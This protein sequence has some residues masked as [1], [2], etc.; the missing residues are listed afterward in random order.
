MIDNLYQEIVA[1]LK[2]G[3]RFAL[4]TI[5]RTR[6]SSP[7]QVGAKMIVYPDGTTW[8]TIG[9]GKFEKLAIE[10]SLVLLNGNSRNCIKKYRF[11]KFGDDAT[12][13]CCGGEAELYM[14]VYT[15][16]D[17]IIIFGGGHIGGE[18][19]RLLEG[20]SFNITVI[21]DRPEFLDIQGPH[22]ETIQTDE[23]YQTN[24]PTIDKNCYV[25]LVT[26]G[27]KSDQAILARII[28]NDMAYIGMIGSRAK[29]ASTFAALEE[30]GI[31]KKAL[32]KIHSPIG[33]DIGGEGPY[34]IA[35]SIIA[36]I[37]AVKKKGGF[38]GK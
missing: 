8:G 15:E 19:V 13:M 10:D 27:H 35:I 20:S 30:Q 28:G 38:S 29:I 1:N 5:I 14:E 17:R 23:D 33:L 4:A 37:I 31:D 2:K 25:V 36:E 7:R 18:L 11:S 9:G 22:A 26:R 12:G 32:K 21:D 6:G 34:E 3:R 24:F 16:S